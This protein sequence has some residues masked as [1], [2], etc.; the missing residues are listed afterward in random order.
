[1]PLGGFRF[2]TRDNEVCLH[3]K[4]RVV[5]KKYQ[6]KERFMMLRREGD[7]VEAAVLHTR[8]SSS[9][10]WPDVCP[11][12]WSWLGGGGG[13]VAW[14]RLC[15]FPCKQRRTRRAYVEVG[16]VREAALQRTQRSNQS[17]FFF[18][19]RSYS[20]VRGALTFC[21]ATAFYYLPAPAEVVPFKSVSVTEHSEV[22]GKFFSVISFDVFHIHGSG[23]CVF[24]DMFSTRLC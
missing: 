17:R 24:L 3:F 22:G 7:E 6:P 14:Q 13:G 15:R 5:V 12:Y 4:E 1:M 11:L 21:A 18:L 23:C 16:E 8:L 20:G 19:Y 2:N 9:Q 10:R